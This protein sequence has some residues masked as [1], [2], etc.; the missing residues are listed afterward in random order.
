[1]PRRAA[2]AFGAVRPGRG[3]TPGRAAAAGGRAAGVE[4]PP[5]GAVAGPPGRVRVL[6][7]PRPAAATAGRA[8]GA[9]PGRRSG[10]P[11]RAPGA[12]GRLGG[13]GGQGER[14]PVA[15]GRPPDPGARGGEGAGG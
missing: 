14:V 13:A 5:G 4:L 3:G 15:P 10:H 8:R 7:L 11:R 2:P 1:R 6:V 12:G 9:L